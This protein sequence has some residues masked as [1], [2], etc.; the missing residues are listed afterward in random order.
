MLGSTIF[1][2]LNVKDFFMKF[3]LVMF[4]QFLG[5]LE[6]VRGASRVKS[7][8]VFL[9]NRWLAA[10]ANRQHFAPWTFWFLT[11]CDSVNLI[12]CTQNNKMQ[13]VHVFCNVTH[14]FKSC[15][16]FASTRINCQFHLQ[17]ACLYA[18][19]SWLIHKK[20]IIKFKWSEDFYLF[21]TFVKNILSYRE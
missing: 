8:F 20:N 1:Y 16:S 18:F 3:A 5:W 7:H 2:I 11:I 21:F 13:I 15:R 4:R 12:S 10:D 19:L 9:Q 17:C 6:C 14:P